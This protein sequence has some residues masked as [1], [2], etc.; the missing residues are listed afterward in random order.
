MTCWLSTYTEISIT[1][2]VTT[3][4]NSAQLNEMI[5]PELQ[6]VAAKLKIKGADKLE[7]EALVKK[8]LAAQ[9][10]QPKP[11]LRRRSQG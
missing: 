7:K 10:P 11:L 5:L 3:C 8:I 9:S 1:K 2:I 6:D 4:T